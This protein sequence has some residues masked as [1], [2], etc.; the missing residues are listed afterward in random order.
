M[1]MM[2]IMES[3]AFAARGD[4]VVLVGDLW[5]AWGRARMAGGLDRASITAP[6]PSSAWQAASQAAPRASAARPLPVTLGPYA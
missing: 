4:G 1:R 5:T 6:E 3:R 2:S